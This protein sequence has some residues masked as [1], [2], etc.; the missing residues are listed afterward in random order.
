M[1]DDNITPLPVPPPEPNPLHISGAILR[2]A[3]AEYALQ[4]RAAGDSPLVCACEVLSAVVDELQDGV[5]VEAIRH[6]LLMAFDS[7]HPKP[8]T[9][10]D[11]GHAT[12]ALQHVSNARKAVET[13]QALI[14]KPDGSAV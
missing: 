11:I 10:I 6:A 8:L 3:V 2:G 7:T 1:T 12:K 14:V 13:R 9:F 4:S 5:P